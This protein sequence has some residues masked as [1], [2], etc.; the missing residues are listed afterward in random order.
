M[1]SGAAK[2]PEFSA[3]LQ[4]LDCAPGHHHGQGEA[5]SSSSL[6]CDGVSSPNLAQGRWRLGHL[7]VNRLVGKC[8][9]VSFKIALLAGILLRQPIVQR[10]I[11]LPL[12][13]W[14]AGPAAAG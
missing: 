3:V 4:G 2:P 6:P 11:I 8:H 10:T 13:R 14:L 9:A 7:L 5:L 12:L 1:M